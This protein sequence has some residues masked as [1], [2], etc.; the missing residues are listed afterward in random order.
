MSHDHD[1]NHDQT[2]GRIFSRREAMRA[3]ARNGFGLAAAGYLLGRATV[4]GAAPTTQPRLPLVASPAMTEGPF[5]VDEKLN[6][7]NLLEGTTRKA[8]VAA[9]PLSLTVAVYKLLGE[10]FEPLRDVQV[11][12]WH[13]DAIGVYSDESHPMN[14]EDTSKQTW[15]RGFQ[16]TNEH[17]LVTFQTIV[18]GWYPGRTPHIHFKVRPT[19]ADGEAQKEFTSQLYFNA[20]DLKP[21]YAAGV[22]EANGQ[23]N[24]SNARDNIYNERLADGSLAGDQMLLDIVKTEDG[25]GYYTELPLLLTDESMRSGHGP[26]GPGGPGMRGPRGQR[27]SGPPPRR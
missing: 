11:D 5:F 6:R 16:R 17:G 26:G 15:L 25:A 7:A 12:I 2:V 19:P 14:H 27:P 23:P 20:D 24:M 10:S 8:V 1:D 13:C 21:I 9:M 22:Y 18:P 3:A 4:A